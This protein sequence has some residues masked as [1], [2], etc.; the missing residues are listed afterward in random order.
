MSPLKKLAVFSRPELS[1]ARCR[2][3]VARMARVL[4]NEEVEK[5]SKLKNGSAD[6]LQLTLAILKPDLVQRCDVAKVSRSNEHIKLIVFLKKYDTTLK[7]LGILF[8]FSY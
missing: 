5:R 8:F 3:G 4:S 6:P 2:S 7:I 1:P